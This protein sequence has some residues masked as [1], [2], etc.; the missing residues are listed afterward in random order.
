M[1]PPVCR[2]PAT[3]GF[4]FC[5]DG[6][7]AFR[8]KAFGHEAPFFFGTSRDLVIVGSEFKIETTKFA[9]LLPHLLV[10]IK[11]D[12]ADALVDAAVKILQ[13]SVW[14]RRGTIKRKIDKSSATPIYTI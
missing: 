14:N 9:V 6:L 11:R 1:V 12:D 5:R 10:K 13:A 7:A 2:K 8:A 3:N 4:I